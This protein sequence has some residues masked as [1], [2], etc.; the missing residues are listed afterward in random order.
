MYCL[1]AYEVINTGI[2]LNEE[3][4]LN[5]TKTESLIYQ[6]QLQGLSRIIQN[7][8]LEL[9]SHY[10][11]HNEKILY[12]KEGLNKLGMNISYL[13]INSILKNNVNVELGITAKHPFEKHFIKDLFEDIF[14]ETIDLVEMKSRLNHKNTD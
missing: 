13:K 2:Y 9:N 8:A 5:S 3:Y 6:S 14:E 1:N 10:T 11:N 4:M 12:F 7:Y